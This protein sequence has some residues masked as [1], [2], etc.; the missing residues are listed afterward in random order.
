MKKKMDTFGRVFTLI[1]LVF[2]MCITSIAL[3]NC[4][5]VC[6]TDI[7]AISVE[8]V[9]QVNSSEIIEVLANNKLKNADINTLHYSNVNVEITSD[10]SVVANGYGYII[11]YTLNEGELYKENVDR[12]FLYNHPGI[13]IT[14]IVLICGLLL[15]FTILEFKRNNGVD[16]CENVIEEIKYNIKSIVNPV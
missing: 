10:T 1:V 9:V 15:F 11:R 5:Y 6:F 8:A 2:L 7:K 14:I 13:M 3:Y 16:Q 4:S 12:S